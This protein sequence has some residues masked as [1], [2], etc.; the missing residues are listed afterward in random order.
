LPDKMIPEVSAFPNPFNNQINVSG[1]YIENYELEIF[2]MHGSL[3]FQ[4]KASANK[5]T[6]DLSGFDSGL[7]IL[8]VI[9]RSDIV[10]I[11]IIKQ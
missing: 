3:L 7:Y 4:C 11:K 8:K 10:I 5:N 9:N 1:K 2:S 6:I